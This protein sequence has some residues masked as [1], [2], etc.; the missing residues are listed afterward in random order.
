MDLRAHKIELDPNN[1]QITAFS[2][3]CGCARFAY[4]WALAE[5]GGQYKLGGKPRQPDLRRLL[6]HI[7]REDYPWML[8]VSK[9]VIQQSIKDLGSAFNHFFRRCAEKK[10]NPKRK[11]KVG[12]PKF[13]KKNRKDSFRAD[14][15]PPIKGAN[16]VEVKDK[17]IC[18]PMIGW[19]SMR[20]SLRFEGQIKSA[21]VSKRAGK[22]FV[23]ILVDVV[24]TPKK[25]CKNQAAI[26][27]V[28]LGAKVLAT[29]SEGTQFEG[30]KPLKKRLKQLR[31][32]NKSVSRKYE[33]SLKVADELDVDRDVTS[34]YKKATDK[35]AKLYYQISCIRKDAIHKLTTWLV[36]NFGAIVIE[37]LNVKGMLSNHK[38]ARSIMDQSFYEFRRQLI[39]KAEVYG[40][41]VGL[42]DRWYPSTKTCSSCGNIKDMPLSERR[43]VCECCGLDMDR[44]LNASINLKNLAV[45]STVSACGAGSSGSHIKWLTKLPTEKQELSEPRGSV[46]LGNQSQ[47]AL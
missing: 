24:N 46:G 40:V 18:L 12:Y 39:Y 28:D 10:S 45:S 27:G 17:K 16:A 36:E 9:N 32:G 30:P 8:E 1:V 2:K 41:R 31:R 34:N 43:Y 23:S 4:N 15:G 6:N 19:V 3:A 25:V 42:A 21:T 5:W 35:V 22:W 14:N 44:D 26:C 38:L 7:K 29:I 33:A 13:K 37:D 20:E 47:I 11:I